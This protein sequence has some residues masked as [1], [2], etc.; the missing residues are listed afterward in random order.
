[1]TAVAAEAAT[2]TEASMAGGAFGS[3]WN[4]LTTVDVGYDAIAG[5][6]NQNQY[7][8]F[9]FSLPAGPQSLSFDF[10]APSGYGDSYSAGGL[11][12]YSATP[13]RWGWDGTVADGVRCQLPGADAGLHARPRRLP[14][15][16]PLPRAQFHLRLRSRLQHRRAWQRAA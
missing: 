11:I 1:M 8:N 13:F 3:A 9:V 4:N 6:G 10:T 14:G 7:D 2:L 15:R 16:Q 5:T 12:L